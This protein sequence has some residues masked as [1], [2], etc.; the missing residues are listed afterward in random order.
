MRLGIGF[1]AS[2]LL[3]ILV[4]LIKFTMPEGP[5]ERL[6]TLDVILVNARHDTAPQAAQ[7]LAQANLEGGGDSSEEIRA[8]SPL[9]PQDSL[10]EGN[11]LLDMV[12]GQQANIRPQPNDQILTQQ[13]SPV[14]IKT[15]TL[16]DKPSPAQPVTGTD[17]M[18]ATAAII[19]LNAEIAEQTRRYN[20]RPRVERIGA[21]TREYRFAQYI[22]DWRAKA[23][24][25]GMQNY[26]KKPVGKY[27]KLVMS[28]TIK[29]DG[30]IKEVDIRRRSK[31]PDLNDAAERIVRMGSPYA[32]FPPN[33]AV[34]TDEIE[35]IRTWTFTNR[36]LGVTTR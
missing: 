30:H 8:T 18:D 24:R 2:V 12:R 20:Q 6:P 10:R 14:A 16:E 26:P 11:D 25:I 33:I 1:S 21:T 4:L 29:K 13:D 5:P 9:P 35:I 22:E 17:P 23:E 32:P 19:K 28:V 36:K 34:D 3:H 27:G 7:A 15:D 31:D